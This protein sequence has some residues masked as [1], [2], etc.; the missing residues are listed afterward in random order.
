M[1]EATARPW[2]VI[3]GCSSG[4]GRAL[5]E[6]CRAAGWGV[7]ASARSL[8]SLRDLP[9][10][11]DLRLTTLDVTR[12]E[13]LQQAVAACAGLRLA[14]LINNAG[15]GQM[16]PLEF[17]RPEEL[18]AQLETN[19]VG[20]HAVTLAFLPLLR[21]GAAGNPGGSRIVHVASVLGRMSVPCAGAY[22][23]SKHAVVALG[24]TLRLELEPEIKVLLVEPGAIR[25]EFRS[26]L[27]RVMGDLPDRVKGTRFETILE[28]YLTRQE[29]H[30]A[31]HGLTAQDCA[32]QIT[33]AMTRRNPP[34]RLVVGAD[35]K[36]YGRAKALLPM[37]VWEWGVRRAFHMGR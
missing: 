29:T 23:A 8:D 35:A 37:G 17:L 10:G 33:A 32:R 20:L 7:V 31:E 15:Y 25:S 13:S 28:R 2:V 27:A 18:R 9:A 5:V 1:T 12:P 21:A 19:V 26:T 24:E 3:T 11:P 30:A 4:I 16:A 22:C 34:R 36:W 6:S 14:G